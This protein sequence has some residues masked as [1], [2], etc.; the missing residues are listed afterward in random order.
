MYAMAGL[1]TYIASVGSLGYMALTT[2]N[3]Q[4][5]RV[6]WVIGMPLWERWVRE[7][8][9]AAGERVAKAWGHREKWKW[10]EEEGR[11]WR[12]LKEWLGVRGMVLD[13]VGLMEGM[14]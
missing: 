10:G 4:M 12:E 2:S 14:E 8:E 13:K 3:D 11:E 1:S 5:E 6:T 7:D 9:R